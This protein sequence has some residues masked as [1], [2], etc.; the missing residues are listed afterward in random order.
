MFDIL[1]VG[2]G[3][4]ATAMQSSLELIA[5]KQH[6]LICINFDKETSMEQL[7]HKIEEIYDQLDKKLIVLADL[8]GGTP[9][10][11]SVLLKK[12][13]DIEIIGGV[14]LPLLLEIITIQN[15]YKADSL[16]KII[17]IAKGSIKKF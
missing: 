14:N 17:E 11:L 7:E 5:G 9:F 10:N 15:D 2:H 8:V 1:I 6:K 12:E 16:E 13:R 4:F 3:T